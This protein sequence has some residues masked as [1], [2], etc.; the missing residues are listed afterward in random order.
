MSTRATSTFENTA[1]DQSAYDAP[2]DGPPLLRASIR[3][4]F[5]GDLTGASPQVGHAPQPLTISPP[6]VYVSRC[7]RLA[8]L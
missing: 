4:R 3:R 7:H 1:E 6:L 8:S 5:R 2:A